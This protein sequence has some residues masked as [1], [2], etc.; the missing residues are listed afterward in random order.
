MA[1]K[2]SVSNVDRSS[3]KAITKSIWN[4]LQTDPWLAL[5]DLALLAS[6]ILLIFTDG[7]LF[8][9][10]VI[11][12]LLIIGAFFWNFR[13]FAI[14]AGMWVTVTTVVLLLAYLAG[15]IPAEELSEIPLLTMMIVV[16][17]AIA[18]QRS[19]AEDTL[20][21]ERDTLNTIMENT[22]T[23]LAYL[24]PE[25]NFVGVNSA[26]VK[27]SGHSREE[28]LG[29]NHFEL[30]PNVENQA[31]F[32]QVRDT[33]QPVEFHAKPFEFPD[34]PERGV[35][36]WDW[37]LAPVTDEDGQVEGLVLSL[38]DVTERVRAESQRDATLEVLQERTKELGERVKELNCLYGIS[39]L[40]EKPG[41]SLAEILQR[42][43]ELIPPGWQYPEITGARVALEGD[44]FRTVHF[45]ESAAWQ[46]SADIIVHGQ[47]SGSVEVC[48]LE[49]RPESDEGPF[50]MEERSLI[51]AIAERLGEIIKRHPFYVVDAND[52]SIKM[53]NSAVLDGEL[54]PG[55]TC[56]AL[57]HGRT[58]P[59][60]EA[61]H[62]CPV[63]EI[64]KTGKPVVMEHTHYDQEG[65]RRV[66]E[67]R[68]HP[69]FDDAGEVA[70]IIEYTLDVTERKQMEEA[71]R[72]ARDELELRVQE[73]T[74]AL[75]TA[76]QAL[77]T[78]IADREEAEETLRESEERYRRLVELAFEGVA[79]HSQGRVVYVNPQ[80]V[81]LM[82]GVSPEDFI[83]KPIR[84]FVHPDYWDAVQGRVR[85][86]GEEGVG[87]PL[88]EEK[89][90]R[91]DG[92]S[93]DVVVASVPI[94]YL[95][96]PAVQSVIH[97]ISPRKRAEAERERERAR[98]A[99][100]LHDS[101][102]HSL[103]Y[104]HLKL[105]QLTS[106]DGLGQRK[107][108]RQELVQMRDVANQAYELVRGM[109]AA[110]LPSNAS[111]LTTA[112]LVQ[113][114]S[115]CGRAG[116][117]VQVNSEGQPRRL[118]PIVQQQLVYLFQE[119]LV[120]VEKH[121]NARQVD[122]NLAWGE[123]NLTLSL[124]DDGRGF[125]PEE[126]RADGHFGLAIM[127]ERAQEIDGQL[128]LSSCP[129][130]GTELVLRLPLEAASQSA[131]RV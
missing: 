40:V 50:L 125:D 54:P 131:R 79:I 58:T 99:R 88:V 75:A 110:L 91:L 101:L 69:I 48:Y 43:V 37:T 63:E 56:F 25:F 26:Y 33:G 67:V 39:A 44:E 82:G 65:D 9:F 64:K 6:A 47:P 111:D 23:H 8:F 128:S 115:V 102:G 84:D 112:L 126:V 122:V 71:L 36:H 104:L 13:A 97:D 61:G 117:K 52:Y 3:P 83:G 27:G 116:I 15:D 34:Q 80:A 96:R 70:Q 109:L 30:F 95:G 68:G 81:K 66:Y 76:N 31:I 93:V 21:S 22:Q 5:L 59:C 24:D 32:E 29:H 87:V 16:A 55:V 49:E 121:A 41:V 38:L 20:R 14:R 18:R 124:S 103:G 106:Q 46:Q 60:A 10:H 28:L 57:T 94:A 19:R 127:Q 108:V 53:A 114:R 107:A 7:T 12:V 118:S 17:F 113:A 90:I 35:T 86:V 123:D 74:A 73:R 100:N 11:F 51:N 62:S 129:D 77:R 98:I 45:S 105:D 85:Q 1:D 42:T 92:T 120:N 4:A 119:A 89:L 2:T 78:E 72:T 130:S